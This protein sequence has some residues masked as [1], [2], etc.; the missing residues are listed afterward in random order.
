MVVEHKSIFSDVVQFV[1]NMSCSNKAKFDTDSGEH[2]NVR[3]FK[4]ASSS[5]EVNPE[6]D[7]EEEQGGNGSKAGHVDQLCSDQSHNQGNKREG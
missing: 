7:D 2:E 1:S 5:E 4:C 3:P 6:H